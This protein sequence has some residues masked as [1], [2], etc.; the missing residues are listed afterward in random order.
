MRPALVLLDLDGTLVDGGGL[1]AAMRATCE[2]VAAGLP[3]VGAGDLVAANSAVWQRL[4][5]EVEDDYMLGGRRGDLITR[6]AWRATL[7]ACGVDDPAHVDRAEREWARQERA[8]LRL[9]PD[10][11][12]ALE[13]LEREGVRLGMVT[14]GAAAVQ[15]DKLE[16]VGLSGRFDPL[17]ISSEAGVKKPDP[18][19]FELALAVSRVPAAETWFVGD[20]LWHDMP[21][22]IEVGIRAVW[23]DRDDG[24]APAGGP[25]PDAII[26]SLEQLP[27]VPGSAEA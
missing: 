1:T 8:S 2:T 9:F 22:A 14:N 24:G 21:G 23:L 7:A 4:W 5:P 16:A 19:I 10:V 18:A 3:G 25:R 15:R 20:N 26:R 13:T 27:R 6:D 11:L 12:P 17:V